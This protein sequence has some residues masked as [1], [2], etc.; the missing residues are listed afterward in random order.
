MNRSKMTRNII[1][2]VFLCFV[3][4]TFVSFW[5]LRIM[6]RNNMEGLIKALT[7]RIYDTIA[8]QLSEPVIVSRTMANDRFLI[9]LLESEDERD[10]EETEA[11]MQA[12]LSKLREGLKYESAFVVSDRS[13]RYYTFEGLVKEISRENISRDQ[14]YFEF[15]GQDDAYSLDVDR[16][17]FGADAWTVFVDTRIEDD[18]GNLLGVCG[19]GVRMTGSQKLFMEMEQE[20]GVRVSL[21]A[22]DGMIM[23]DMDDTAIGKEQLSGIMLSKEGD[24][25]FQEL[26][27]NAYVV[28]KFFDKLNWYLVVRTDGRN[29]SKQVLNIVLLNIGM[30]LI[31]MAILIIALRIIM[32]RTRALANASF[33]DQSTHLLNRRAF[34]EDKGKLAFG[35]LD[36][37][38]TYM[39]ADLNGLKWANDNL[40]HA[41]GDELIRGAAD[42]LR[43]TF[44]EY[45]QVYRIGGD[46]FAVIMKL[47]EQKLA[48]AMEAFEDRMNAWQG[49]TVKSLS[50]SYGYVT[51]REFPSENLQELIRISDERMYAAK[52]EYYRRTGKQ[53][54]T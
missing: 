37:D 43:E 12:Y 34:E 3:M 13:H 54:R 2:I 49:E 1:L 28:T 46:E 41:A 33:R 40:G 6:A 25:R 47:P 39:T 18:D 7:A 27:H 24:Y 21:A 20:Y 45:G 11:L 10:P 44:S 29:E 16:D 19:V 42:C 38:F 8:G 32:D 52:D 26:G 23:V 4:S 51:S 50:V 36:T 14:W 9:D 30:C 35:Q 5:S 22:P 53:R 17:E 31:A 15:I 48:G